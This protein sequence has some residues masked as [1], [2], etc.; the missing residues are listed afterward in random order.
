M[1]D[2]PLILPFDRPNSYIGRTVPRPNA[3]RLAQGR[4]RFVDD[5]T[6][7]RMLHAAFVRSPHAHARITR[8][9]TAEASAL[10]GVVKVITGPE[11]AEVCQSWVGVLTHLAG[12]R[13]PPQNALAIDV[14]RW[15]GEGVVAVVAST[16][17]IAE[18]AAELVVVKYDPLPAAIDAERALD[19]DAPVIHAEYGDNR[20]WRREVLAGEPD[21]AF[22]AADHVVEEVFHIGRHTGVTP[23]ARS[24]LADFDP[25][26]RKLT[27]YHSTQ[28]PHMMQGIFAERFGLEEADVRVVA[29]DVGGG[30]GLK[31]HTYGDEIAAVAL[32]VMLGRP[33]KYI[34]DRLESFVSDIHA[35]DHRIK[36]RVAVSN[37]GD[38]QAFEIEDLTGIGPFSMYP[39]TSAIE[40]NQILNLVG[41]QYK[42]PNYKASADVV[43]QNKAMMCQYRAVGH[44]VAVT[45]TEGMVDLA[46][47][48]IGMDPMEIRRRNLV[49]DDAYPHV[50]PAGMRFEILSQIESLEK[51]ADMMDYDGLRAEQL[52]LR[53]QGIYRG[54]G[55][56]TFVEVT[57]PSPMFYGAGGAR[58]AA[59]DGCTIKLEPSG[60]I[61]CAT[62]VTEQG[63][64]T[65]AVIAQVAATAFGVGTDKVRVITGDT[66]KTPYGGGTWAS[67]GAG[68]GGEAAYQAARALRGQVLTTAGVMLQS[69][70]ETLE[71]ADGWVV[72]RDNGAQRL[73]LDDLARTVYYRANELPLDHQPEMM[74]T[75]HFRVKDYPFVFTNGVQASW[76][77]VDIDTGFVTLLDHW[78]VEDCGRI[79][80]PQL[81]DEQVRGGIVQ[82]IGGALFE[83]CIY[84]DNGQLLN[85]TMADYLVPM[86][87]EM[88]DIKVGHVETPTATSEIGAKGAGEAGTAGAGAAIMN[89][90]NDALSPL[91]AR[92]VAQPYTPDTI[93]RA[94]GKVAD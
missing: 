84:D 20:A 39:R 1:T 68:I 42:A 31:V 23:E 2:S 76:L 82:G 9:D 63:Q 54:I 24:I 48:A 26:E 28:S 86:P 71:I 89:A 52:R 18:D 65:E 12:L 19:A 29:G 60:V 16:R 10:P 13:S 91:N 15:Q 69:D 94:L 74:A 79:I 35:R 55:L 92:V 40:A 57:N 5:I 14:A 51:L 22:A 27:V 33:V 37:D 21:A 61:T 81:V 85:G 56:A 93:L 30:Y 41:S 25:S 90:I 67:R 83:H 88:P 78:C 77:E 87:V 62:G 3:P 44:P 66:D 70:P 43:F 8:I 49:P 11:L 38:I 6:L 34:A 17:E 73:G 59:Q 58:I 46:A 75:K 45:V 36:A 72:D 53:E 50:T 32:S 80:N 47:Q 4:G 7:P 64:G